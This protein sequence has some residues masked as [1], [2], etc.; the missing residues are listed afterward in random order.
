MVTNGTPEE[1][2]NG[3]PEEPQN[4]QSGGSTFNIPN[5]AL[6]IGGAG[7]GVALVAVIVVVV[8]FVTGII[9]GASGGASGG[10]GVLGY[11]PASAGL[12]LIGDHEAL[13]NGDVPEDY[14]EY[15]EDEDEDADGS[16]LSSGTYEKIDIDG[17]DVSL[18]AFVAD[19]RNADYL[20]IVQGD[21]DF[22]VIREELEDGLDCEDDDYRG[23]ELWECP[24]GDFP[25]V[26]LFEKDG[27]LVFALERQ[28][29]LEDMLTYKSRDPGKLADDGSSDIKRILDQTDGGWLQ[30]AV[31]TDDCPI[32]RCQGFAFALGE[33]DD[34]EAIPASY[35]VMFSSERAAS[36]AEGDVEI[37]DLLEKLFA[38][39]ALELDIEE[40]KAEG[41]FVVGT[42]EA[43]FVGTNAGRSNR[44]QIRSSEPATADRAD[45]VWQPTPTARFPVASRSEW[46][47]DCVNR[48]AGFRA[49]FCA[50]RFDY[51][52]DQLGQDLLPTLSDI[53]S[54][55]FDYREDWVRLV[56][57]EVPQR[58]LQ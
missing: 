6:I 5:R 39:L 18:V 51:A 35:A 47:E 4:N 21:F 31:V 17:D 14:V 41:E 13:L 3:T 43:E 42:G 19:Q 10:G 12:V 50:C 29:D 48:P 32:N 20:E 45:S 57:D 56:G 11:I 53:S 46:I 36:G 8:L 33:S 27:Y 15:M 54:S 9:G 49:D 55:A 16:G 52:A 37:D 28:D 25:A 38:E 7:G 1:P 23:F 2:Q 40:V 44:D 24:G 30:M 58:C 26:A 34:S 22:D